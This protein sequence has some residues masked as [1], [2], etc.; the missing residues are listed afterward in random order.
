MGNKP[1]R[2]ES[3]LD[4]IVQSVHCDVPIEGWVNGAI[5]T[6]ADHKGN[7]EYRFFEAFRNEDGQLELYDKND[8]DAPLVAVGVVAYWLHCRKSQNPF[9]RFE[10]FESMKSTYTTKSIFEMFK[11]YTV[12][13]LSE[14]K[15]IYEQKPSSWRSDLERDFFVH[16]IIPNEKSLIKQSEA[17][18]EYITPDDR[19][20]V[21]D[22][23]KEYI[24]FLQ[25]KRSVYLPST[26]KTRTTGSISGVEIDRIGKHF[27]REFDKKTFLP[28]LKMFLEQPESDKN[29]ARIALIIYESKY[30][31][32][33]DYSTFSKWY[34][35]FCKIV[36]CTYHK[37]Y[38]KSALLPISDE[39]KQNLYFLF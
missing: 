26:T 16:H 20:L 12:E 7:L 19:Q 13:R 29:L 38:A 4:H 34:K 33:K 6:I 31:L 25:E 37:S 18:F 39:L 23:M 24:L 11:D 2:Y 28:T 36:G 8:E 32:A 9:M 21:R 35:D 22:V 5:G 14:Y 3:L 17:I 30:F 27:K 1:W 15:K 10:L